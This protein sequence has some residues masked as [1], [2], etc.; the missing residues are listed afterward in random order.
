M[1]VVLP[2]TDVSAPPS[3]YMIEQLLMMYAGTSVRVIRDREA[4]LTIDAL[5]C[6]TRLASPTASLRAVMGFDQAQ[7]PCGRR[8]IRFNPRGQVIP[9]VYWP[10]EAGT[11]PTLEDLYRSG[12][13]IM[14]EQSF[15]A[16]RQ[17]PAAASDCACQGGCASRRRLNQNLDG[18][19]AYCPWARG[20]RIDLAW[21]A[22]PVDKGLMRAGN[23]C[24][25][26]V[27]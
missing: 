20:E 19:D 16:A 3:A 4:I 10:A 26:I 7:S 12:D 5:A 22:A 17:I 6:V 1:C 23:V 13:R 11:A 24:T 27:A 15:L 18:H 9:C 14:R 21:E 25:T 8:S 2:E